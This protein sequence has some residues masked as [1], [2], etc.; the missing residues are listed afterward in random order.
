MKIRISNTIHNSYVDGPGCRSVIFLQGCLLACPG[1]QSSHTHNPNGGQE[2]D[3]EELAEQFMA[4]AKK[5]QGVDNPL[6]T[7]SGGEPFYNPLTFLKLLELLKQHGAGQIIVYT[8][9]TWEQLRQK[10]PRVLF[11]DIDILVDGPYIYQQDSPN[12]QYRGS[13]NQRVIDVRE[14]RRTSQLTLLDWDKP[15]V[16][17]TKQGQIIATGPLADKL[18]A[19]GMGQAVGSRRCG[20]SV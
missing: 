1:C 5:T 10:F 17:I 3:R 20:Q 14:T 19:L 8:G 12:M 11:D 7:I 13:A 9:H 6:V 4:E 2:W 16:T 18:S 15:E